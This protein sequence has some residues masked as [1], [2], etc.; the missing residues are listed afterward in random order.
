[1]RVL[2]LR[3]EP[4]PKPEA[5]RHFPAVDAVF[6]ALPSPGAAKRA[7]G[8]GNEGMG[9]ESHPRPPRFE[10][11][12]GG[13]WKDGGNEEGSRGTAPAHLEH[14]RRRA[15]SGQRPEC[16]RRKILPEKESAVDVCSTQHRATREGRGRPGGAFCSLKTVIPSSPWESKARRPQRTGGVHPHARLF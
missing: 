13:E 6:P 3:Q 4:D 11:F 10:V 8:L 1:M 14:Q 9:T 15:C 7:R 12:V 5:A 2:V 16:E